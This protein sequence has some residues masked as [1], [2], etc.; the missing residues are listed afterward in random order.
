MSNIHTCN[1]TNCFIILKDAIF[2]DFEELL[3]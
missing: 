2:D 1:P 3:S